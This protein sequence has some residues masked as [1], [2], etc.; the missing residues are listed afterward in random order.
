MEIHYNGDF[1]RQLQL[2]Y[3]YW[4]SKKLASFFTFEILLISASNAVL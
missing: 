3:D 4:I 2:M 1:L